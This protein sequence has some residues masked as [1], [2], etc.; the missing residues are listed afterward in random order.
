MSER[1]VA[2][3]RGMNVGGHRVKNP[4]LEAVFTDLGLDN[5]TG[6]LASGNVV[7][8]TDTAPTPSTITGLEL[9]ISTALER[10]LGYGVPTMVRTA[11]EVRAIATTEPFDDDTSAGFEGKL[12]AL[13]IRDEPDAETAS[14]LLALATADDLLHLDGRTLFWLPRGSLLESALELTAL[15]RIVG[16]ATMRTA[17]TM[18]RLTKKF[19]G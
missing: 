15:D 19:L 14:D 11:D 16:V 9:R 8:D 6:Y 2:F 1:M 18:Q 13:L 3:L 5:A 7:F 10:T 4:E 17:N 12:Q